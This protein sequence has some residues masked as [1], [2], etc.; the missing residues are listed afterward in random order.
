MV[1]SRYS[2]SSKADVRKSEHHV[3]L[4]A[5]VRT[6]YSRL[7]VV[8]AITAIS[9][10][11]HAHP[12]HGPS[13]G[14][15]YLKLEMSSEHLRVVYGLTFNAR[16]GRQVRDIADTDDDGVITPVESVRYGK[17]FT[18][19]LSRDFE[20]FVDDET[21]DVEWSRPFVATL[22]GQLRR[23]P[24]AFETAAKLELAPGRHQLLCTDRAEFEGIYRT[25][26]KLVVGEEVKLLRAGRG[27]Q[28][29]R[30]ELRLVFLDLP[31]ESPPSPRVMS[32]ELELP[33]YTSILDSS[34][35]RWI[36]ISGVGVLVVLLLGLV[37][38]RFLKRG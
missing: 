35:P 34:H 11:V 10:N 30:K 8:G 24:V 31:D 19:I 15:R 26:A 32:I 7:L 3:S 23:G 9:H 6:G 12:N 25:T 16:Y 18:K 2:S 21:C 20:L 38:R 22:E 33:G 36:A 37:V 28:P 13:W 5:A 14:E 1:S 4:G 27:P 29:R 17:R